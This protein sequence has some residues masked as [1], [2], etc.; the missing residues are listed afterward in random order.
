MASTQ[1]RDD[2]L[3]RDE[4]DVDFL[5]RRLSSSSRRTRRVR[6]DRAV[7]GGHAA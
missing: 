4:D 6:R 7:A 5:N 3:E 1:V 2:A